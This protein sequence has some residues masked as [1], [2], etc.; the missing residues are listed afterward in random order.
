M[1]VAPM[2]EQSVVSRV[3]AMAARWAGLTVAPM[4]APP[5]ALSADSTAEKMVALLVG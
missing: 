4:V 2:A 3:A 5:V 1:M